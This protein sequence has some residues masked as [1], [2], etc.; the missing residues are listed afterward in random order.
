[1]NVP[2]QPSSLGLWRRPYLRGPKPGPHPART[3]PAPPL[4]PRPG[5][6][7][8]GPLPRADRRGRR[9]AAGSRCL[10][11]RHR[12][13]PR[14][15]RH[16]PAR[17]GRRPLPARHPARRPDAVPPGR[18]PLL[19]HH[20]G[21]R[22]RPSRRPA[23]RVRR[24]AAAA[25][26]RPDLL[27][28]DHQPRRRT[29]PRDPPPRRDPRPLR[30]RPPGQPLDPPRHPA[31]PP[32]RRPGQRQQAPATADTDSE[33]TRDTARRCAQPDN[34]RSATASTGPSGGPRCRRAESTA[35]H[36]IRCSAWAA[37][38]SPPR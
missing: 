35:P 14:A 12:L 24:T 27:R 7:R 6:R 1:M 32:G 22:T 20:R 34:A 8:P 28:H 30:L 21:R 18:P 25:R 2:P 17:P 13:P 16:R 15:R 26:R 29:C 11:A 10:A 3:S 5:R 19:R 33:L 4:G 36:S 9:R 31:D 37:R 23:P 38:R